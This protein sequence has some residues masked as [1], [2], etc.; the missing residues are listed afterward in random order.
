MIKTLLVLLAIYFA[1]S[2][3]IY[4]IAPRLIFY[5]PKPG[6]TYNTS[7][8]LIT[9]KDGARIAV[10]YLPN[11]KARYTI[12]VSHGNAEDIGY[13][14]PFLHEMYHHG[15]SVLAYDYRSYGLSTGT[16]T[17]RHCF[18]D[19]A[20]VYEYLVHTLKVSPEH[21]IVYGRSVGAAMALE[22]AT[23]KPVAG[24]I[25]QSPFVSA[26][27]VVTHFP[28]FIFDQYNNLAKIKQLNIPLLI[29]HG[30]HD[31]IVPFWHSVKLYNAATNVPMKKHYWVED[32]D[33]NDVS[34]VAKEKYWQE[35]IKFITSDIAQ[36]L[37]SIR[38]TKK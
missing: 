27:R 26:Y 21:I 32:A 25:M 31:S 4:T 5:P 3:I 20:A 10:R 6:Y 22:L 2:L 9:T 12:L 17:E 19:A 16:P 23:R 36:N 1:L 37:S 29:I 8:S 34:E 28:I 24:I 15:F 14:L 38:K 35:F 13:M 30:T 7:I 11:P 33:H 18:A